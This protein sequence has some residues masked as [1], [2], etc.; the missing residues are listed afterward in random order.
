MLHTTQTFLRRS[1]LAICLCYLGV[2]SLANAGSI[3]YGDF[4]DIPPG[5]VTYRDVTES[6]FSV[7]IPP[8][9]LYG[10]PTALGNTLNF[11][12]TTGFGVSSSG[13]ASG[14][15]DGQVNFMI[16]ALPGA[17]LTSFSIAEGG[18]FSFSGVLPT[19][20]TFVAASAGA[21]VTILAVDGVD[22]VTPINVFASGTF[23][24][25]YPTQG[26][27]PVTGLQSWSL[28]TGVDLGPSIPFPFVSGASKISVAIDNQLITGTT[29]GN[30]A[31]IAK[32]RFSIIPVGDLTPNAVVPEPGTLSLAALA[33]IG[34]LAASRRRD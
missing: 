6:S 14:L 20:G 26:G 13:G 18:D 7:A 19:P 28:V 25:D 9:T 23:V 22:L 24:R 10:V 16:E 21:T 2:A 8:N 12:N 33:C 15:I 11:N 34:M 30:T 1:R 5:A 29:A 27:A 17:G 3:N 31:A 32:K 4:S